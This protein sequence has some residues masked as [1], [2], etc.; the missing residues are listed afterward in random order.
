MAWKQSY[1]NKDMAGPQPLQNVV[2]TTARK[3]VS[4]Y[5]SQSTL[6]LPDALSARS[7]DQ[8][9]VIEQAW[10]FQW[11]QRKLQLNSH[12]RDSLSIYSDYRKSQDSFVNT[13][14]ECLAKLKKPPM[15][16]EGIVDWHGVLNSMESACTAMDKASSR[17]QDLQGVSDK[18]KKTFRV[19]CSYAATGKLLAKLV[20]G[21][22]FGSVLG[23]GLGVV[24]T[25]LEQTSQHRTNVHRALERP[26]RILNI[27]AEY[28][29]LVVGHRE[30]HFRTAKLYT[31]VCLA[32][33]HILRWFI[34][35]HFAAGAK[36][37]LNPSAANTNLS[38][39][40]AEVDLAA[41]SLMIRATQIMWAE[42]KVRQAS[43][44]K[45]QEWL[46]HQGTRTGCQL[47]SLEAD[48]KLLVD[49]HAIYDT[50]ETVVRDNLE[51]FLQGGDEK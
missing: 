32:L 9:N 8:I 25:C 38:D 4:Q 44:S 16:V 33:Q 14:N 10:V 13:A 35:N 45:A 6:S 22:S 2:S 50:I 5:L 24:F 1:L 19:F 42:T 29:M 27:N 26:P 49:R 39:R 43:L 11:R 36:H 12:R 41:K 46:A 21:D 40:L 20:P 18:L 30:V 23:G 3:E 31:E 47:D 28:T 34:L 17:D 15:T 51:A 7:P 48:I 37:L